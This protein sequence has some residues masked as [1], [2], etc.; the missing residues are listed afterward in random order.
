MT[1]RA[2]SVYN[3][4]MT[5]TSETLTPAQAALANKNRACTLDRYHGHDHTPVLPELEPIHID[6]P[7]SDLTEYLPE[8]VEDWAKPRHSGEYTE[9]HSRYGCEVEVTAWVVCEYSTEDGVRMFAEG[10]G[11]DWAGNYDA[12]GIISISGEC[13]G[14]GDQVE[15][16]V[17]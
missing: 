17:A 3:G 4:L 16:A 12:E 8:N 9:V 15:I 11:Q 5:T 13:P 2:G 7:E 10:A 14:C 6:G 1:F